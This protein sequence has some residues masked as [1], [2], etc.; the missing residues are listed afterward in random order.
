VAVLDRWLGGVF[1]LLDG[2][3]PEASADDLLRAVI[4]RPAPRADIAAR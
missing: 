1:T 3:A 4:D 2:I